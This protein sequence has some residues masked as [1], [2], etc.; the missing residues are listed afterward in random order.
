MG[1]TNQYYEKSVYWQENALDTI[2][3]YASLKTFAG[4][5]L[6]A[7]MLSFGL[8]FPV[9]QRLHNHRNCLLLLFYTAWH[10]EVGFI[11]GLGVFLSLFWLFI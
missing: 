4:S 8:F 10:R 11:E 5:C 7:S 2:W 9:C 3:W 6:V 1:E